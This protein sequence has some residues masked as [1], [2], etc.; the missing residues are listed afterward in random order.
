MDR[1]LAK[2]V[3]DDILQ[4]WPVPDGKTKTWARQDRMPRM[5]N[6]IYLP[7]DKTLNLVFSCQRAW[8][9]WIHLI[10]FTVVSTIAN[11]GITMMGINGW[12]LFIPSP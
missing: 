8:L 2:K 1:F 6:Q 12:G 9:R 3:L 4:P 10:G 7:S 11:H 5:F